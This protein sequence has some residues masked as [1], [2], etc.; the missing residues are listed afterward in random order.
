MSYNLSP[1]KMVSTP[2][3]ADELERENKVPHNSSSNIMVLL[4][5]PGLYDMEIN[6][7]RKVFFQNIGNMRNRMKIEL[8]LLEK[9]KGIYGLVKGK[10]EFTNEATPMANIIKDVLSST[11][12]TKTQ[13]WLKS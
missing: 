12:D 9:K 1:E 6:L 4:C 7:I 5:E 3:E 2:L 8:E 11:K 13:K 10:I